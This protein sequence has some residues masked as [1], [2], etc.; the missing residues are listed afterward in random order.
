MN[1]TAQ[2]RFVSIILL[3]VLS[4]AMSFSAWVVH[5]QT[6]AQTEGG[7]PHT[8]TGSYQSTN[9]VYAITN[10]EVGIALY[11]ITGLIRGDFDYEPGPETQ[12]LGTIEGTIV[13]GKY[14]LTL[15]DA[16]RGVLNDFDGDAASPPEVQVFAPAN[17]IE[18]L[19]DEYINPGEGPQQLA[20]RL[21]PMTYHII[22][23]YVVVWAA[24][25]GAAFPAGMGMDGI[26]F[27]ADDPLLE[28]PAG[29]SVVALDG[30]EFTLIRDET[31]ELPLIESFA[32]LYDYYDLSYVDAWEA[33]YFRTRETYPF[34][35]DKGLDWDAIYAEITPLVAQVDNDLDFHLVMARFGGM[36]PDTH[37]GYVSL[38]IMQQ[39]LIGG[40]GIMNVAVTN[41]DEVVI[42]GI[43][44]NSPADETGMQPGDV[45]L[46]IDGVNALDYLDDTPLLLGSA[47]TVHGRRLMQGATMLQGPIGSQVAVTW[48]SYATGT[49]QT[50]TFTRVMDVA[51]LL[52][53]F[54]GDAVLG[55]PVTYSLLE[56]G[57]GYIRITGFI[58]D[59]SAADDLFASA[60]HNLLNAG[61]TGIILDLRGNPGGLLNLAMAMAGHF[62]PEPQRLFDLYYADG[63]GG[64]AYRGHAKILTAPPYYDGPVAVLVDASTGS[65]GD[66]FTYAMT[67]DD[68]AL[69]VGHTPSGGFT[70]EVSDG[71]YELPGGLTMQIP[72]GRPVDPETGDTVIEGVG[73]IPD[74]LVP[75]TIESIVSPEDEVLLTA[76]AALLGE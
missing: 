48:R 38:A 39:Y 64:F 54:G 73:V 52:Q 51:G 58:T 24:Q 31:V 14:T 40:F 22:G 13:S 59:V 65:A 3:A 49:I 10:A 75:L 56:S 34:T 30:A 72:T 18:F 25:E 19:G 71:Q 33:L 2:R 42:T 8:I 26:M 76:E 23:G 43:N 5:A 67:I 63:T 4:L 69:V 28:L 74:I 29:W 45:L 53:A 27:T 68:R 50:Q 16:P 21:E 70:G 66:L 20:L 46:E 11:D 9:P 57:L 6:P 35:I 12:V 61:A 55:D 47:S 41:A 1:N 44:R 7:G 37:V 60:M 15:P 32:N 36:I 62:F 17:F